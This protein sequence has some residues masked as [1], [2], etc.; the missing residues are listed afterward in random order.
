MIV[1]LEG[2]D[3]FGRSSDHAVVPVPRCLPR[4][5]RVPSKVATGEYDFV[6]LSS[7]IHAF[8]DHVFPGMKI[9]GCHQFRVTRNADL[10]V[11]EDEVEDLLSA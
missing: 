1:S 2:K 5:I 3:A 9:R 4:L 10:L 6:M 8:V 7:V 11:E